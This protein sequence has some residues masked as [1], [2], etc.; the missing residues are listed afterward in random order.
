MSS[1]QCR[2]YVARKG[3]TRGMVECV[4]YAQLG[5]CRAMLFCQLRIMKVSNQGRRSE[6]DHLHAE[7]CG[8]QERI[9]F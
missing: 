2:L 5:W 1:V 6:D 7:G 9:Q 8:T 3:T 4:W